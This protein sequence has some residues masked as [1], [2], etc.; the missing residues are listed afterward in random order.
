M[1]S[2]QGQKFFVQ[3]LGPVWEAM[4]MLSGSLEILRWKPSPQDTEAPAQRLRVRLRWACMA[5][6]FEG[7][8][9]MT[10]RLMPSSLIIA[11]HFRVHW[12]PQIDFI[13]ET[14]ATRKAQAKRVT[15][16]GSL[17]KD[18]TNKNSTA[19]DRMG[20]WQKWIVIKT[21]CQNYMW[22]FFFFFF[23]L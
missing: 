21:L 17:W 14:P 1:L 20:I 22:I 13:D 5:W 12:K 10:A 18:T 16:A 11:T 8:R 6:C 23:N 4:G 9:Q 19:G 3:R 15:L 2:T 7:P